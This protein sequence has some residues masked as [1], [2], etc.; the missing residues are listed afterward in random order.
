MTIS[1]HCNNTFKS[2]Y[3]IKCIAF[4]SKF[5]LAS[6]LLLENLWQHICMINSILKCCL[7]TTSEKN[8][9]SWL[10]DLAQTK[11][12]NMQNPLC[13]LAGKTRWAKMSIWLQTV[14]FWVDSSYPNI[15]H[16]PPY[17]LALTQN[18]HGITISLHKSFHWIPFLR[19]FWKWF[20]LSQAWICSCT[21]GSSLTAGF[22]LS[23]SS[24]NSTTTHSMNKE[25]R[26]W[27]LVLFLYVFFQ[28]SRI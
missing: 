17:H 1:L 15:Q 28:W 2:W 27:E 7:P 10:I 3:V 26:L 4:Y 5:W 21:D 11:T 19:M 25:S 16:K 8:C 23:T 6:K 18:R 24:F 13:T 20:C 22:P 9:L 12:Q 14:D